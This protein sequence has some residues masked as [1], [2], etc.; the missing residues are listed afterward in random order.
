M[1]VHIS[2]HAIT[3]YIKRIDPACWR[4]G[5]AAIMLGAERGIIAATKIGCRI[6]RLANG[7]KLRVRN[8]TVVTVTATSSR[9]SGHMGEMG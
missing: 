4:E 2:E 1:I 9:M 8:N 5:A 6:V 3:R 7:A